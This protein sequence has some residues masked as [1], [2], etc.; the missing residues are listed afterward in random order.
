VENIEKSE[1]TPTYKTSYYN[2]PA[3]SREDY[4]YERF[5]SSTIPA[6]KKDIRDFYDEANDTYHQ[7]NSVEYPTRDSIINT[8]GLDDRL[9]LKLDPDTHLRM[10]YQT[11]F[12]MRLKL[13][14]EIDDIYNYPEDYL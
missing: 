5:G 1:Y 12:K 4:E 8:W 3:N 9:K 6:T 10:V 14:D 13:D 11:H 7:F 2:Y